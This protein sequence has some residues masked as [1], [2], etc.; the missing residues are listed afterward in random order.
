MASEKA[1]A[2]NSRVQ[3]NIATNDCGNKFI[4]VHVLCSNTGSQVQG[5]DN[6]VALTSIQKA[7]IPTLPDILLGGFLKIKEAI[8]TPFGQIDPPV[9]N[10]NGGLDA[11]LKTHGLIPENGQG[12]AFGYGILTVN[13]RTGDGSLIVATTHAGVLDSAE[14][15]DIN[16]PVWH[17]HMV[18]LVDDPSHCGTDKAVGQITWEQPGNVQIAGRTAHL[19]GIPNQFSSPSSFDPNGPDQTYEPGNV[20]E[21]VVS[22]KLVPV[23]SSGG[24]APGG[25]LE[26][27]C[28][29][30]ITPADNLI[31]K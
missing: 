7:P 25:T 27:V 15:Q 17:N 1:Y 30:E 26:A 21:N 31:V 22:F 23:P 12:G 13:T 16:D 5:D 14:Q 24:S 19:T 10:T 9:G 20:A 6:A 4:P 29:T 11:F 2:G 18:K 28:V 3:G 8:I